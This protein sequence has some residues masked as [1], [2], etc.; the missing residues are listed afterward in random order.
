MHASEYT[1]PS[2][3]E[4]G[5]LPIEQHRSYIAKSCKK[6]FNVV[7]VGHTA[8]QRYSCVASI[9][10]SHPLLHAEVKAWWQVQHSRVI[11]F[12]FRECCGTTC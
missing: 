3:Q 2:T 4:V 1:P 9:R 8:W 11:Q 5:A 10:S 12:K 7:S 6:Y